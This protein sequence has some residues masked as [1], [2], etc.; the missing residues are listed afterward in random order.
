MQL[1]CEVFKRMRL[2]TM[3]CLYVARDP[4]A[5]SGPAIRFS[6]AVSRLISFST[7]YI[8]DRIAAA[9]AVNW[10]TLGYP[11]SPVFHTFEVNVFLTMV[12][13]FLLV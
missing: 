12:F 6:I 8:R 1:D 4:A 13:T 10:L 3:A 2:A 5:G 11:P 9:F 7:Q